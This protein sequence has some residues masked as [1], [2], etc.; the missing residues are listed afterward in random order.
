LFKKFKFGKIMSYL[1]KT[2]LP[3][4]LLLVALSLTACSGFQAYTEPTLDVAAL[5]TQAVQT[6][7]AHASQAAASA[8]PSITPTPRASIT[9]I[10]VIVSR[11]PGISSV[12]MPEQ[13]FCDYSGFLADVTIPDN[14]V[15]TP[16]QHFKKTW[17]LQNTGGCAWNP[18]YALIFQK[19][20]PMGGTAVPIGLD[21]P[22][23]SQADISVNLVAPTTPGTY[24]GIWRLAND[25]GSFF[26]ETVY[27]QI[28]VSGNTSAT[29]TPTP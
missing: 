2:V 14:T 9:P 3:G 17:L 13:D 10:F 12:G 22:V 20:D 18:A 19:G 15:L 7:L 25:K 6:V 4:L 29:L 28:V 21:V 1:I 8:Q 5:S 23:G 16:G 27:V 11:I 26:G 24:L